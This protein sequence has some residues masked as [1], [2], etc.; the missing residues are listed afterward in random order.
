MVDAPSSP[1][2]AVRGTM[3]KQ[4]ISIWYLKILLLGI[5]RDQRQHAQFVEYDP[6]L[7]GRDVR[8]DYFDVLK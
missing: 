4:T 7:P 6:A 3:S 8:R 5:A 1:S 2:I